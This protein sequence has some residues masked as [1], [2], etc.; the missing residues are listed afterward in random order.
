MKFGANPEIIAYIGF[1]RPGERCTGTCAYAE[2]Q[3]FEKLSFFF[4]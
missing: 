1:I 4:P 3:I 2:H